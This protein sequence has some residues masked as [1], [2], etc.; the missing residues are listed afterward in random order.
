MEN[1]NVFKYQ[2]S[3][4]QNQEIEHIRKKYLPHEENKMDT[5]RHLDMRV[6]M[7]GRLPG[8][9]LGVIGSLIFGI[10]VCIL[11][12]VF[13]G[14]TWL[15]IALLILGTLVM[16]PAYP[17]YKKIAKNTKEQLTPEIL[18]LSDEITKN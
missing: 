5:L 13:A 3:A 8:L 15:A 16:I 11:L 14:A 10:G 17:L 9:V 2:Y 7:A 4:V 6:Q 12:D 1:S 18:K